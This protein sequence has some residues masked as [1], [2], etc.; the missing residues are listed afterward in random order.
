MFIQTHSQKSARGTG[1]KDALCC[2][3]S[4][5]GSSL[6]RAPQTRPFTKTFHALLTPVTTLYSRISDTMSYV[7]YLP[8]SHRLIYSNT[9]LSS[10]HPFCVH[11]IAS[12]TYYLISHKQTSFHSSFSPYSIYGSKVINLYCSYF[13]PLSI[14]LYHSFTSIHQS[15]AAD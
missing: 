6:D 12:C 5:S 14:L 10:S 3:I 9:S 13:R 1:H 4:K 11:T 2:S 7:V 8:F 15:E